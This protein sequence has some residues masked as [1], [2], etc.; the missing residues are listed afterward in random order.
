MANVIWFKQNLNTF[1]Y[2][3]DCGMF[4]HAVPRLKKDIT[5]KTSNHIFKFMNNNINLDGFH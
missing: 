3:M 2:T 4:D 1:L 5:M